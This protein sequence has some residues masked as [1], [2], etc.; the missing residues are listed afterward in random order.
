MCELI[1]E[2]FSEW[3]EAHSF[4]YE[5]VAL[6]TR[7]PRTETIK[8]LIEP[9]A[10]KEGLELVDVE[11]K[12]EAV[13]LV[14]RI[15]LDAKEGAI[16]V[17]VLAKASQAISK[18]LDEADVIKQNFTLEVS[19]PGIERP[20]TKPDHFKRFVGSKVLIKTEK[21]L[22]NRKQFK[23]QLIEAGDENFV[24][25]VNGE[26]FEI[27]YHNVAKARLQVEIEF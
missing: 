22:K 7:D 19:S 16:G 15:L 9:I 6:M 11:L 18:V 26:R 24:V 17:D 2:T 4:D 12:R 25:E 1:T 21:P 3:V 27:S 10:D 23:G 8:Q 13:G 5:G 14:L 20:L